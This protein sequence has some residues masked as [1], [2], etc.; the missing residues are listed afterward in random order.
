M[1]KVAFWRDPKAP[2]ALD[3]ELAQAV[4]A[5]VWRGMHKGVFG[6]AAHLQKA[7]FEATCTC[8]PRARG[9]FRLAEMVVGTE[10]AEAMEAIYGLP[11]GLKRTSSSYARRVEL[12]NKSAKARLI[13]FGSLRESY[14]GNLP[15][16]AS[17]KPEKVRHMT[18]YAVFRV[19]MTNTCLVHVFYF[20]DPRSES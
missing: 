11:P 12:R 8:L 16:Q 6:L 20:G 4:N 13:L 10:I 18:S 14:F 5:E 2:L 3:C 19:P 9:H 1:K 17:R 7:G 15:T